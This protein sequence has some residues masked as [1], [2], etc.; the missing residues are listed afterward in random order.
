MVY[1]WTK[2]TQ[3][4]ITNFANLLKLFR[5]PWEPALVIGYDSPRKLRHCSPFLHHFVRKKGFQTKRYNGHASMLFKSWNLPE[6][7]VRSSWNVEM[8][9][10]MHSSIACVSLIDVCHVFVPLF[11]SAFTPFFDQASLSWVMRTHDSTVLSS[12]NSQR[13]CILPWLILS[14]QN[15]LVATDVYI[16]I[17]Y[18][19]VCITV[20][21]RWNPLYILK[22]WKITSRLLQV[23]LTSQLV[24]LIPPAKGRHK[25]KGPLSKQFN[26][27]FVYS[28]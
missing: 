12:S 24:E 28:N 15:V 21:I 22:I 9:K 3:K 1:C 10:K 6:P 25:T 7:G 19:Y 2:N 27:I 23:F 13:F 20:G 17:V 16:Y 11:L 18:T 5:P 26:G 14:C 4:N 8:M